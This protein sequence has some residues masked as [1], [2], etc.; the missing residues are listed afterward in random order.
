MLP[1]K[2]GFV[3]LKPELDV[4]PFD[5]FGILLPHESKTVDVVFSPISAVESDLKLTIRT[6][7]NLNYTLRVRGV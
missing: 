5:G 6:T 1:Q 7:M 4:Q 2:F 3:N